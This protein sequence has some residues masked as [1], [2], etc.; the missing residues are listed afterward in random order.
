LA[1]KALCGKD[2][3]VITIERLPSAEMPL[4]LTA[5][6]REL[7]RSAFAT[8]SEDDFEHAHGGDHVVVLDDQTLLAHA[9]VVPRVIQVGEHE[10]R[11]GYVEAV[12][13]RPASQGRGLGSKAMKIIET[14]IRERYEFGALCTARHSFYERLG[15]ERWR[16]PSYV[17]GGGGRVRTPDEDEG[18]MV[19]RHGPT[20]DVDLSAP[21]ACHDRSGDAW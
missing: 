3:V 11:T 20:A 4:S 12:G 16:G 5:Q 1:R 19:L 14:V 8:F 6:V 18:I 7:C 21:I 2:C 15:W 17:I 10:L 9:A 13:T